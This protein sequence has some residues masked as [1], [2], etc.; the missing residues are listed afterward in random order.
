MSPICEGKFCGD[1]TTTTAEYLQIMINMMADYTYDQFAIAW[2]DVS[3][4]ADSI[5]SRNS[6]TLT[7][8]DYQTINNARARCPQ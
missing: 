3:S 4:W 8:L 5:R 2:S 7:T 1:N 6:S